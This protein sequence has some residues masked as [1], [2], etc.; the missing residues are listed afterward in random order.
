MDSSLTKLIAVAVVAALFTA[1]AM[2]VFGGGGSS[3]QDEEILITGSTTLNP[4]LSSFKEQY[5]KETVGVTL[6][7]TGGGSGHG[8]NSAAQGS[9]DIGMTSRDVRPSE[10]D[11][12]PDLK[13]HTIGKDGVAIIVG[14]NAGITNLDRAQVEG[15]FN[16]TYTNWNQVGGN[17]GTIVIFNRDAASGTRDCFDSTVM[18]NSDTVASA[19]EVASNGAMRSSVNGNPNGIGYVGLG[20]IDSETTALDIGGVSPT[21]ENVASGAYEIQRD[22]ILVTKGDPKGWSA[23]FL[24]W[25]MQP[26]AQKIV[27]ELGFVPIA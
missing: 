27:G 19:N 21:V 13:I 5:E 11:A 14:S 23:A 10:M 6:T 7:I 3:Y 8:I 24:E 18:L 9:A 15:I 12:H 17:D 4:I 26:T 25:A 20:F 22:L 2:T 1:G 16:G